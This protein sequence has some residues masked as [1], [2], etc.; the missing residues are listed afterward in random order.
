MG[1]VV[2]GRDIGTK[3]FPSTPHKFFLEASPRVRAR[4]ASAEEPTPEG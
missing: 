2:E 1:A 4:L 3:V